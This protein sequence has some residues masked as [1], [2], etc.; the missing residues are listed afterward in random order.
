MGTMYRP[1]PSP[2]LLVVMLWLAG[3]GAAAQFAKIAIVFPELQ[4]SY[5][6]TGAA[7]GFLV[8]LISLMGIF[9]GMAAGLV[10]NRLGLR[11]LLVVG[12]LLGAAISFV[13]ALMPPFWLMLAS[14]F[15]E[16][17]SHLAIVVVAPTLIAQVTPQRHQ[18]AALTLWGTFFGVAFAG[19]ALI[20]PPI[21]AGAGMP[22]LFA[23]HGIYMA[24]FALLIWLVLP[25]PS[26]GSVNAGAFGMADLVRRHRAV[27][28][29][30]AIAAPALG[31]VSYTLT[32]VALLAVLPGQMPPQ[33]RLIAATWMPLASIIA[34]MTIGVWLLRH[35]SAIHVVLAG[36]ASAIGCALL[37]LLVGPAVW[38]AIA[39]F[40]CLGLVQ[41][42]SFA[43]VPQLNQSDTGRA[44]ANGGLA[45]MGNLGNTTGTPLL[46][47][48]LSVTGF[49]GLP[50]FLVAA[51]VA[52]IAIHLMLARRRA[53]VQAID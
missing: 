14:R 3:L 15:I 7:S 51:Y 39:L 42:A 32:F 46:I 13:Q 31:W 37:L 36:Y 18:G 26:T 47:A 43:A 19:I 48:M 49:V 2:L 11:R 1:P 28:A 52:A 9:L 44:L 29:D 27:Y 8:S 21:M 45:Q 10:A 22:G 12:L 33:D 25:A 30:P 40:A 20:A 16:G 35:W 17:L 50:I 53:A 6:E 41:G 5:G 34:S 38:L 24:V 23:A 4:A